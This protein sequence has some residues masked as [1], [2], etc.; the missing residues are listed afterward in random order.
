MEKK[1]L[2]DSSYEQEQFE[3]DRKFWSGMFSEEPLKSGFPYDYLRADISGYKI[4]NM[5][6]ELDDAVA[7][8][9]IKLSGDSDQRLNMILA[10]AV[11]ILI[12]KYT[13]NDEVVVVLPVYRQKVEGDFINT[14]LPIKS[15]LYADMTFKELILSLRKTIGEAAEHQNYPVESL[16]EKMGIPVSKN[17]FPMFDTAMLLNNIHSRK[18]LENTG[19]SMIFS[20]TRNGSSI[21]GTIEYNDLLYKS[22]TVGRIISHFTNIIKA[23]TEN[24]SLKLKDAEMLPE[25]ERNLILNRFNNIRAEYPQGKTIYRLFEEQAEH[26]P[27]NT[28]VIC[29]EKKITYKELNQKS[30]NLARLLRENGVKT[31]R[32]VGIMAYRSIEMVIAI[33]AVLKAGGAYLPIDPKLPVDRIQYMLENSKADILLSQPGIM[34]KIDF[35][36]QVF[37]ILDI[38]L[39]EGNSENTENVNSLN[40]LAYVIYTSGSTGK[41]KGVMVEHRGLVNYIWWAAKVY[42]KN[43]KHNFPLYTT[44]AFDLTVTSI[45]TPLITGNSIVVYGEDEKGFLIGRIIEENKVGIIKLTPAHLKMIKDMDNSSSNV[46]RFIV[47]GEQL[48]TQLSEQIHKS[49]DGKIEIYNEYGPTETTVGCMIYKYDFENDNRAAVPIGIPADNVR[50]YLLDKYMKPVPENVPGE[51]YIAGDG[52]ARGYLNREELTAEKFI[53]SP[54]DPE[55]VMYKTGDLARWLPDGNVEFI[56]RID[57]QVKIHGYRIETGEIENL[58]ISYPSVKEAVV[59]PRDSRNGSKYLCAYIVSSGRVEAKDI[60]K[61]LLEQ[62]PQYMVPSQFVQ[63]ERMPLTQNG[64]VDR[65]ALPEPDLSDICTEYVPPGNDIEKALAEVWAEVLGADRVGINDSFFN[66]GGDSIKTIQISVKLKKYRLMVEVRDIFEHPTI[67]ELSAYVKPLERQIYQ[68]IVEG[69]TGLTPIQK[70]FFEND[71]TGM[72]HWNQSIMIYSKNGF[73]EEVLRKVFTRLAEHH[74][75]LRMVYKIEGQQITQINRGTD[76]ELFKLRVIDLTSEDM[77]EELMRQEADSTQRGID[78]SSGPLVNLCLFKTAQGDHLLMAIHHLVVDGISWRIILEDFVSAYTQS[79]NA[80]DIRFPDKTDSYRE[81]AEKLLEYASGKELIKEIGY[82]ESVERAETIHI[83]KDSEAGYGRVKDAVNLQIS[84]KEQETANLLKQVNRAYNTE[85]ND[86]LLTALG[87][88]VKEWTGRNNILISMEGHGRE[89]IIKDIDIKRTVGWFTSMYPVLLDMS[90]TDD[91]SLQIRTVKEGLRHIP[92]KGIG[93]GILKYLTPGESRGTLKFDSRPDILFNYLGQFDQDIKNDIYEI[94]PLYMGLPVNENSERQYA[95]EINGMVVEGRLTL[96]FTYSR[97]QYNEATISALAGSYITGLKEIINHCIAREIT[98]PTPVDI[99]NTNLSI[100]EFDYILRSVGKEIQKIYTLSPMQEGI[101]FHSLVNNGDSAYFLQFL[102]NIKGSLNTEMFEK[103][104][105]M[106]VQRHDILRTVFIYNNL[107]RPQQVVLKE[108]S[109][110]IFLEDISH[111]PENEKVLYIGEFAKK[112]MELGFDLTKDM[113]ARISLLKTGEETYSIIWSF[114]HIILDGWGKEILLKELFE[115]Y[116]SFRNNKTISL[117]KIYPYGDYI[118]WLENQQKEE[119]FEYWRNY[120][121]GYSRQTSLKQYGTGPDQEG[122]IL[123]RV[124]FTIDEE[125]TGRLNAVANENKITISTIFHTVWA[126]LLQKYNNTSDVLFGSV[127]CGRPTE[128]EGVEH[129]AGLFIN[130][131]PVRIKCDGNK[132][133]ADIAVQTQKAV[134]L[135]EKYNYCPLYEIQS[136]TEL[137]QELFDHIMVFQ[138]YPM[139]VTSD[140]ED[141]LGFSIEN[142]EEFD[143]ISYD[144]SITVVPGAETTI[145]FR[146]N[147]GAYETGFIEKMQG[148]FNE[149]VSKVA[150]NPN[151]LLENIEIVSEQEIQDIMT[152]FNEDL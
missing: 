25:K 99:G 20:F 36:G 73:D 55:E 126:I 142:Y 71:F 45:Y 97:H 44:I 144:F 121:D 56:G 65:K 129:M 57:H 82:W 59:L 72:N 68:G 152:D 113:L 34:E 110:C 30:N 1:L 108:R 62:L 78:L 51:I 40:D 128:V 24:T 86:I 60:K 112:D 84:L 77:Y 89:E 35:N 91:M 16:L 90:N 122:Y 49:F 74:D 131:V 66:L 43:E 148:H 85:I 58:L 132:T 42:L 103:S 88:A 138:N 64:K 3:Q 69:E 2:S 4:D 8:K 21:H 149:I 29:N 13:G 147:S 104:F 145:V 106:L 118:K 6:F 139:N 54:F 146:Y 47:G 137:R 83:P 75:A 111:L 28:A 101:L 105:N 63:L 102:L 23:A 52:V 95:L 46:K 117:D 114:H 14:I 32:I 18:Y 120:L 93:Y 98:L 70:W 107:S 127:V 151:I 41:P 134:L 27:D 38:N 115:V 124:S 141:L 79:S 80:E 87:M 119:T 15:R 94:S 81:W 5:E 50:I 125:T 133:F 10:A 11:T 61:Y 150:Q 96:T 135:S 76:I 19:S 48:E 9:L 31:D 140:R 92:G 123:S 143:Q 7:S 100:A 130:T 17:V 39:Y 26:T 37:N 22:I 136:K 53:R 33:I 67:S 116:Q 12:H 109:A